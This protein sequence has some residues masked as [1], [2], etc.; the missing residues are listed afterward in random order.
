MTAPTTRQGRQ[1][2]A[3]TK[4]AG[5]QALRFQSKRKLTVDELADLSAKLLPTLKQL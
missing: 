4:A 2:D 5:Y 3:M 1:R